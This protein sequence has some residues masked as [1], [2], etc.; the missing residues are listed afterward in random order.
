MQRAVNS[1]KNFNLAQAINGRILTNGL[2]YSL[3]TG[4]SG[5]I[6]YYAILY[7]TILCYTIL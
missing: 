4:G 3:A 2:K 5:T 6:L 7:Y 1:G